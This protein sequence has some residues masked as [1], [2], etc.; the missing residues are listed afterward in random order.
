MGAVSQ[1]GDQGHWYKQEC[2]RVDDPVRHLFS[3][4]PTPAKPAKAACWMLITREMQR[5][6]AESQP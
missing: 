3:V 2:N 6:L 1:A 5:V 4:V